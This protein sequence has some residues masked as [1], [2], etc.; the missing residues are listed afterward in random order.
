LPDSA[1]SGELHLVFIAQAREVKYN[2]TSLVGASTDLPE[3]ETLEQSS[4]MAS[5]DV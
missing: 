2:C 5:Q 3:K 4:L 1:F